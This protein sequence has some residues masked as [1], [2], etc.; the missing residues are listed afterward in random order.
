MV[1]HIH[2]IVIPYKQESKV[3]RKKNMV[4][5]IEEAMKIIAIED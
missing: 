2:R 3:N 4:D 1:N 5:N